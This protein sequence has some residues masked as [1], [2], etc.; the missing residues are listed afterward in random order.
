[1]R[2]TLYLCSQSK[3]RQQLLDQTGIQYKILSHNS[4]ET[5]TT[6]AH[7]FPAQV[8]AIAY[9]KLQHA[10]V[11]DP[12][13]IAVDTIF[14]LTA[15]T[16]IRTSKS[17]KI[18]GKPNDR[19]HAEEMLTCVA[20]EPIEIVTGCCLE[21]LHKTDNGWSME[22]YHHWTSKSIAEFY[23]DPDRVDFYFEQCPDALFACGACVVEGVGQ[24]F[25][26]TFSGSYSG[27]V[28]IPLYE[29]CQNLKSM[30]FNF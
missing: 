29:L 11:P 19:A 20:Q 24:S 12:R 7:D 30:N 2:D 6:A 8:L 14:V 22:Q 28:G 3:S 18:L 9:D 13:E 5:L 10:L 1:M 17:L 4:N 25:L 23:V 27:A 15:D 16:L 21:K 26:K